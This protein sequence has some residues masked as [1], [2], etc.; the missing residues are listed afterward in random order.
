MPSSLSAVKKRPF[1]IPPK[2]A[3]FHHEIE[4][5][6][7]IG[8]GGADI[9]VSQAL[10]HVYGYAVGLDM[11]RRDIQLQ[12]RDMGRPSEFGK[13]FAK[14]APV[15]PVHRAADVGHIAE[16][17]IALT[18]NGQMRQDSD[19]NK[20]IWSVSECIAYRSEYE[21]LEPG[22]ITMSGTPE[23]VNA[24]QRGDLIN[25]SIAGLGEIVVG[26]AG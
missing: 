3:N 14:S 8:K 23:G 17:E 7:A 10:E 11:P 16:G 1:P 18:V 5:V 19:I 22:D 9:P 13:S 15:G 2:T 25:G 24:V 20:L 21:T 26:V 6:V 12:V 4:L